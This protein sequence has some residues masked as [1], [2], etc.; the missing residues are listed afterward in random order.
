MHSASQVFANRRLF[1]DA[2]LRMEHHSQSGAD[3][4][5]FCAPLLLFLQAK[6][7]VFGRS[8]SIPSFFLS[9]KIAFMG[10]VTHIW[11]GMDV[12]LA[13]QTQV[14]PGQT[15]RTSSRSP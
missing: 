9:G 1:V 3:F 2:Q 5:F 15:H 7:P 13:P 11:G 14:C 12:E 4:A 6:S 10:I 8:R